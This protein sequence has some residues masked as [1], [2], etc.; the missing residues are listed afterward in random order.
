MF[1]I[2]IGLIVWARILLVKEKGNRYF[3]GAL[4]V[5]MWSNFI[6]YAITMPYTA[7]QDY[8]AYKRSYIY[9]INEFEPGYNLLARWSFFHGISYDNF[10]TMLLILS[11]TLLM[12]GIIRMTKN[13]IFALSVYM[14]VP[15]FL[16]VIQIRFL[17]MTGFVVFGASFLKKHSLVRNLFVILLILL[18]AQFHS[19]GYL[20]VIVVAFH[21]TSDDV[22]DRLLVILAPFSLVLGLYLRYIP[23]GREI[24]LNGIASILSGLIGRSS[25]VNRVYTFYTA[26]T[27]NFFIAMLILVILLIFVVHKYY[28]VQVLY[29]F[30]SYKFSIVQS[31][32]LL[33]IIIL[34]LI[35]TFNEF[36]RLLR[37]IVIFG[38]ILF[39]NIIADMDYIAIN[40]KIFRQFLLIG[41][42]GL[43]LST[44]E[45]YGAMTYR[46]IP[47]ILKLEPA[48]VIPPDS[49]GNLYNSHDLN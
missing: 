39:S 4:C 11:I 27:A 25:S 14:I 26:G 46:Q 15:F 17:L 30:S 18:G 44:Y 16:D 19:S 45:F 10:R 40:K 32:Q 21:L 47:I 48:P 2:L 7:S 23:S 29:K 28:Q 8:L 20:F 35:S 43:A 24:L 13:Y 3:D 42:I 22:R 12:I 49:I 5:L 6:Y 38:I 41:V 37:V 9:Q 33:L 36:S 1:Y 34:P 31:F